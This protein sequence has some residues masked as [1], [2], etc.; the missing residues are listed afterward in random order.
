VKEQSCATI[1]QLWLHV[2]FSSLDQLLSLLGGDVGEKGE[3]SRQE[4]TLTA[5]ID[6][7]NRGVVAKEVDVAV[8]MAQL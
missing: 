7:S 2:L 4:C 3:G 1:M 8:R 6:D 5:V